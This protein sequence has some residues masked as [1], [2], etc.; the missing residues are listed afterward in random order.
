ML[1]ARV[2]KF[3][4]ERGSVRESSKMGK[5]KES[6]NTRSAAAVECTLDSNATRGL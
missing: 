5:K 6:G 4:E 2:L 1:K 3:T